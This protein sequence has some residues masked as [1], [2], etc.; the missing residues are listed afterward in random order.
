MRDFLAGMEVKVHLECF[1]CFVRQAVIA[2]NMALDDGEEKLRVLRAAL[3]D[4]AGADAGQSPA[5]FTTRMHRRL[6]EML[7]TDPFRAVKSE[8]NGIAMA[9]YPELKDLVARSRYPLFTAS[10]LAIAGNVIDFGIFTSV[11]LGG[12]LKRAVE[13]P[14]DV[15]HYQLFR[16]EVE[17][18]R[19]VLYL[20]D[21]AGEVVFDRVLIE[22]L[23]SMGKEVT[24]VAKG[25][26]VINDCT[27]ADVRETG[28]MDVC[29]VMD[30]GSDAVG[31]ILA[32][33]SEAFRRKFAEEGVLIISKGQG[34]FET[35]LGEKRNLFFLFQSKCEVVSRVLDLR[36]GAM[37][38]AASSGALLRTLPKD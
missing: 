33:T 31:T 12:T 28:L 14:M 25:D 29:E 8:Y 20:L 22:E 16:E 10:R 36:Q 4:I 32:D 7:G 26:P 1:P 17:R 30:N 38:L 23:V 5:H 24:A 18:A 13:E 15:D 35:L 2:L 37:L 11:D 9:L 6:R 34:N 3:G 21:N 19:R 27:I